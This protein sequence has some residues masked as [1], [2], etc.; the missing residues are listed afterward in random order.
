MDRH[1]L[2]AIPEDNAVQWRRNPVRAGAELVC[3][4]IAEGDQNWSGQVSSAASPNGIQ[5]SYRLLVIM[6]L[7]I[8]QSTGMPET[9]LLILKP[10][11]DVGQ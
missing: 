3:K 9:A 8:T 1:P 2:D 6:G 10:H 7:R 5:R 4:N 11:V